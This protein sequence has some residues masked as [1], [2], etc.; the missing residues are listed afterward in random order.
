[1]QNLYYLCTFLVD[2][3]KVKIIMNTNIS[4]NIE[5]GKQKCKMNDS[6]LCF[7]R[8]QIFDISSANIPIPGSLLY[9]A[10]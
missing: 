7:L 2:I 4:T 9:D 5:K 6:V 10:R 3:L 1:M 8:V